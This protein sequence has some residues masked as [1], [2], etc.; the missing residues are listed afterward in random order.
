MLRTY[1]E[2]E[3]LI[4]PLQA[5]SPLPPPTLPKASIRIKGKNQASMV[6]LK[7]GGNIGAIRSEGWTFN[8]SIPTLR[9]AKCSQKTDKSRFL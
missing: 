3:I 6:C 8:S 1:G 2:G 7:E 9:D 4:P 5:P